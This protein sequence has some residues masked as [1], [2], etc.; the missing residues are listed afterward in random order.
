MYLT[1]M[2]INFDWKFIVGLIFPSGIL[3]YFIRPIFEKR[4]KLIAYY[5][6]VASFQIPAK[7]ATQGIHTHAVIIRNNGKLSAKNVRISHG[8]LPSFTIDPTVEYQISGSEI[9]IPTLVPKEQITVSYLYF[10]PVSYINVTRGI[11][12]DEGLAKVID[13]SLSPQLKRW[14]VVLVWILLIIGVLACFWF[15]YK[16]GVLFLR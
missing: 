12:S 1:K 16:F 13:V 3:G 11:K 4:V 2:T 5:G 9:I 6:H 14:Q 15:I 10:P 8:H 7:D